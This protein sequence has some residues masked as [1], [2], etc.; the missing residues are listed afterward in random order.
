MILDCQIALLNGRYHLILDEGKR[1]IEEIVKVFSH[2]LDCAS[3]K[4]REG[5]IFH[6]NRYQGID[7]HR[8]S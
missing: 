4:A 8:K 1:K 5:P 6:Y 7:E 3:M 2:H